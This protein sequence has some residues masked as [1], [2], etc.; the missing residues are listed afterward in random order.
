MLIMVGGNN[1]DNILYLIL[2]LQLLC[3]NIENLKQIV[4]ISNPKLQHLWLQVVEGG[5]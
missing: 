2:R 5:R 4:H 1:Q 3:C